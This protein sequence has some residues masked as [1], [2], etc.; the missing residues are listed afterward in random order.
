MNPI[1]FVDGKDC[2]CPSR[3]MY[4]L[5]DVSSSDAGRTEDTVMH[6]NR[7]GSVVGL[8][9]SW[10]YITT[11]TVSR[12]LNLFSPEYFTVTYLDPKVGDFIDKV[13]YCGNVSSPMYNASMGLWENVT[14]NIIARGG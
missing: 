9:L 4:K 10:D 1:K 12:I 5:E 13:F 2:P 7:I 6:K 14:F 11:E 8:E 3:Y